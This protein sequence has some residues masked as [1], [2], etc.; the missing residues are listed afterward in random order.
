MGLIT[1]QPAQPLT[2]PLCCEFRHKPM[3]F[4][5]KIL[6]REGGRTSMPQW[7]FTKSS[8]PCLLTS[9]LC[10][11]SYSLQRKGKTIFKIP[12]PSHLPAQQSTQQCKQLL[13]SFSSP[14]FPKVESIIPSFPPPAA[15]V[16][17]SLEA[18]QRSSA[19]TLINVPN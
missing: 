4:P 12:P 1:L 13:Q 8:R 5:A 2:K 19:L 18:V 11:C 15:N 14:G 10:H 9:V 3:L 17:P 7:D 16:V 6:Q